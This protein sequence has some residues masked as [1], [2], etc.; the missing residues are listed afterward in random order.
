MTI[1]TLMA[2]CLLFVGFGWTGDLYQPMAL[3]VGG[4]RLHRRR[5]RR[6]DL[7]GPQDRLPGGRDAARAADRPHHRRGRGAV[8]IGIT[9]QLL[10]TADAAMQ[11]QGVIHPIGT[12][13]F[14]AP[15]GTLMATLIKGLLALNLDWQFVL[16]GVFLAVTMELCGVQLAV[17]RG[18]R[19]PAAVDHAPI[20]A[21]GACALFA[22]R[23]RAR[24][25]AQTSTRTRSSGPATC[26][27]PAWSRA[28]P[29]GRRVAMLS[30]FD[31]PANALKAM[32][33]EH[34]L[35]GTPGRRRLPRFWAWPSSSPW[36][37]S[38]GA[39]RAGLRPDREA[40]R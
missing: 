2:T 28:A 17:L 21:G 11:P 4:D 13:Q 9:M 14:P 30:A 39:W 20:F 16:V 10:D 24:R 32:S 31:G 29:C 19:L 34:A 38:S 37:A 7:A 3:C 35:V 18:R 15:Q 23:A 25:G 36:P 40:R 8:V 33:R 22:E 12:D 27:P 1:A 6:R 26:S 5:Q